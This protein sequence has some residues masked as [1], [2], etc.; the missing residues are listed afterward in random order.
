MLR[1]DSLRLLVEERKK[2]KFYLSVI[3]SLNCFFLL[4]SQRSSGSR[5]CPSP[6]S[7]GSSLPESLALAL[8]RGGPGGSS[9]R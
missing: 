2:K 1:I 7:G 9:C 3:L 4:L 6:G 5:S 8:V